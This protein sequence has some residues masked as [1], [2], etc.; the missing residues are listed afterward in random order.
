MVSGTK[1]TDACLLG[2]D[3]LRVNWS[4]HVDDLSPPKGAKHKP[5]ERRRRYLVLVTVAT[6]Q[7]NEETSQG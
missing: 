7:K 3:R 1:L 6:Y 4:R 2:V 5:R